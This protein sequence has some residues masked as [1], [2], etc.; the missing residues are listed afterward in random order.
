MYVLRSK[1]H[2]VPIQRAST[3]EDLY[4]RYFALK[5]HLEIYDERNGELLNVESEPSRI[6]DD[7]TDSVFRSVSATAD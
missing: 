6:G 5:D 3:V 1:R 4:D 2:K 7:E